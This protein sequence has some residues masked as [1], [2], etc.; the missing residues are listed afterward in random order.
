MVLLETLG[1]WLSSIVREGLVGSSRRLACF[2][3]GPVFTGGYFPSNRASQE[4]DG[5]L[6]EMVLKDGTDSLPEPSYNVS[7][8]GNEATGNRS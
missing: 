2:K 1:L 6:Q 7:S 3:Y 4:A 5:H 8:D